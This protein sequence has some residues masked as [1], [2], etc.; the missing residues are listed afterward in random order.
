MLIKACLGQQLF[1]LRNPI[2]ISIICEHYKN[3]HL[4]LFTRMFVPMAEELQYCA[5]A[6]YLLG[7]S[8]LLCKVHLTLCAAASSISV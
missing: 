6:E 7:M 2:S 4:T 1:Y 3:L 5:W 8:A